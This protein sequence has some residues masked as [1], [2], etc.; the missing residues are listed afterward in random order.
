MCVFDYKETTNTEYVFSYS[1]QEK[2]AQYIW[3]SILLQFQW[4]K[5]VGLNQLCHFQ[6]ETKIV[7]KIVC[8]FSKSKELMYLGIQYWLPPGTICFIC[9][10]IC[11]MKIYIIVLRHIGSKHRL[12]STA[13][14][15]VITFTYPTTRYYI[16]AVFLKLDIFISN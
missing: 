12:F 3:K 14:I 7:L 6:L 13:L 10:H 1:N 16:Q 2:K 15:W 8:I 5:K 9:T 4:M 11:F